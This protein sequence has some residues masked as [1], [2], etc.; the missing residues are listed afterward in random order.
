M[1]KVAEDVVH[2]IFDHIP[3]ESPDQKLDKEFLIK[4]FLNGHS[5]SKASSIIRKRKLH[6]G[7]EINVKQSAD[8]Y[9]TSDLFDKPLVVWQT[10]NE[11]FIAP[12]TANI[13][14]GKYFH[15]HAFK[16]ERELC[17][18]NASDPL[19]GASEDKFGEILNYEKELLDYFVDNFQSHTDKITDK[20]KNVMKEVVFDHFNLTE[21]KLSKYWIQ[22]NE[23]LDLIAVKLDVYA[24]N[25][26]KKMD[27]LIEKVQV[28]EN[29]TNNLTL[30]S[31]NNSEIDGMKRLQDFTIPSFNPGFFNLIA[32]RNFSTPDLSSMSLSTPDI[33]TL[34]FSTLNSSTMNFS[35]INFST[36]KEIFT[37]KIFNPELYIQHLLLKRRILITLILIH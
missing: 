5:S 37:P 3:N 7:R 36:P 29:R 15:R 22:T 16:Q 12:Y 14:E 2:R 1:S 32:K 31:Q 6:P 17:C 27:Y 8:P 30:A 28:L 19:I 24:T 35:T 33:S 20:M 11:L 23:K 26:D 34:D 10:G 9:L 21:E 25:S 18:M 13:D 4:C